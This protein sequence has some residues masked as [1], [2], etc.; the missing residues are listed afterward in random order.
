LMLILKFWDLNVFSL[1]IS[2]AL[3]LYPKLV[4]K[5]TKEKKN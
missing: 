5:V 1:I 2:V 3:G 4:C